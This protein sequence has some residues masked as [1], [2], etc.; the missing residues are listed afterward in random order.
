[1]S[2]SKTTEEISKTTEILKKFFFLFAPA[3]TQ[4]FHANYLTE[5]Y[6]LG[7]GSDREKLLW[8]TEKKIFRMKTAEFTPKLLSR[9]NFIFK[10][11]QEFKKL[12]VKP[13]HT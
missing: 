2:N 12:E 7:P 11:T 10:K 6:W 8:K 13:L 3:R 9:V 4:K 5:V 1:M